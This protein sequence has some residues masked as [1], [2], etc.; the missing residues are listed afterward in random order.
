MRKTYM[1]LVAMVL[2]V[3]GATSAFG[4]KT[5]K[6]ELDDSMFKAWTSNEPGAQVDPE[7]AAEPKNNASFNCENNLYKEVGGYGCIWGSSS[8]Y[9]L[10]YADITGT[11]T[12]TVTGT[13]GMKIRV[14]LNREP[15]VEGGTGDLDGGAYVELIQE[16]GENGT[17]VFDLS[18]YEYLHLNAIKVPGSGPGGVVRSIILE[19]TV[20]P[21]TGLLSVINNGD[22]EGTDL[23]SFPVSHNGGIEGVDKNTAEDVPEIVEG[24]V[25]GKCLKVVS[26]ADPVQTWG[27]QFFIKADEVMPKGS[28][29]RLIMSIKADRDTKITTSAQAQ[30]RAWKGGFINEFQV[31][32]EW[33]QY[34]WSGE[35]GVDD[36]QSIAFDLNNGDERNA[37]D[38]GWLPGND[39][40]GFY[41]DNIEFGYDLGGSNPMSQISANVCDGVDAVQINLNGLTNMKDLVKATG[42]DRI[43]YPNETASVT[44][45]GVNCEIASVEGRDD[46]NL[47]I[48]LIYDDKGGTSFATNDATI[49]VAFKNPADATQIL[50]TAGKW[51]GEPVPEFSKLQCV[52]D[53]GLENYMG[54]KEYFSYIWGAPVVDNAV[55]EEG[56]FNLPADTKQFVITFNQ[57]V[58]LSSVQ[59]NLS[60]EKL[61]V[62]AEGDAEFAK[63]ITLTRTGTAPLAG[64]KTLAIT[65]A[66]GVQE[67]LA[68]LEEAIEIKYSFGPV[69]S[70]EEPAVIYASNFTGEGDDAN[71]AGWMTTADNQ[72]GLQPANS[73][74]GNRLQHGQTGYAAD[75]LYLAQRSAA[76]GIAL[77]GTEEGYK[78]ELQGGTTYHL[79]LKSAQWDAYPSTGSNRTLRAQILTE[80]AVSFGEGGDGSILD[81]DGIL[82][83]EFKV[84]DGRVK[85]DKEF[86]AFD[87]AFTPATTGNYVI[88]LVAGNL[89]G[90]PAGFGD[91]NAIADVK[92]E[93]IPDVMGIVETK[94]LKEALQTAKDTYDEIATASAENND[95]Y[96][97]EDLTALDN[98]IKEVEANM[99]SYSAPSIYVA[100]TDELKAAGKAANDHK[101]ACDA[102]DTNIKA[103]VDIVADKAESKFNAT[104][105]Y[106]DLKAVTAKY[107]ASK[108]RTN[109][110]DDEDP[111]W[112]EE[113]VFDVLK[114]KAALAE[115]SAELTAAVNIGNS[116]FTEVSLNSDIQQGNCGAAVLVERNRLGARTLLSLGVDESDPLIEAVNNSI[117]D[118]DDLAEKIKLNIK[119]NLYEQLANAENDVFG[120]DDETGEAK[121]L[122]LTAFIKNP[123]IYI[124]DG[125]QDISEE[126]V[127]GWIYPEGYSKPGLFK[128]WNEQRNIAGLPED[129]AFTTYFGA[130]R[131]EQTI[132]DLP[133]GTYLVTLCGSDWSNRAGRTDGDPY[134]VAGFVYCKTSDTPAVGEEEEE[135]RDVNFA[136]TRTI[137]YGGQYN[138]DHALNLGI[139]EVIDEETG[140][141][142]TSDDPDAEVTGITVTDGKLTI[143][144]NFANDAQY[145]FQHA[146]LTMIAPA[147]GFDYAAALVKVN[148]DIAQGIE[149]QATTAKVRGLE[150]YDLNGRR[151]TTARKGLVIVKKYMSDGTVKTEKVI[152]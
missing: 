8:V 34:E 108:T 118:N 40:C 110:G 37:D 47:Y 80:E 102:Y 136:A 116:Y 7:P 43:I 49:E 105:V 130:A 5:Y 70:D 119:K 146:R 35:I 132:E 67:D 75:V 106:A 109:L 83:E 61:T 30:P 121:T 60:G 96:A 79:T 63:T 9:Y 51:E 100:K 10:W 36:F 77:Y 82:A 21:V 26:D 126:T 104:K 93:Y 128:K 92:I 133:A 149:A 74:S 143:G 129:C 112:E 69:S 57:D 144:I 3:L 78:L 25:S 14:M 120:V 135:D 42:K 134:D 117:D 27:T 73:G 95:R 55:P 90:N 72:N 123:N 142:K 98:L 52:E 18:T 147:A 76:A 115:A 85:E 48:F 122:D 127:P 16:I 56:S 38:N 31:G 6:A 140:F 12:M 54:D 103:A 46:G 68:K 71:G 29:W 111:I 23:S 84:V 99:S 124:T 141:I 39:G 19:G 28:K 125:T 148:E 20:K 151:I 145:F 17:T 11:K 152:K 4:Q 87:I 13:V 62:S 138:M 91:G 86:T 131:M 24:G 59:A 58:K 88:R 41:F 150:L 107:H 15:Y 139:E 53:D 32:T 137:V 101:S 33:K 94:N 97:G 113:Y 50:F 45:N 89:D 81:E 22:A 1:M 65:S 44:W 2:S 66:V 64:S 114:D